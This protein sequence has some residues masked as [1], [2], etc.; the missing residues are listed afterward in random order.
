LPPWLFQNGLTAAAGDRFVANEASAARAA[1]VKKAEG[2]SSDSVEPSEKFE[3]LT[4]R[5]EGVDLFSEE[6]PDECHRGKRPKHETLAAV[7]F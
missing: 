7:D 6:D 1:V 5:S 3:K 2:E 4:K